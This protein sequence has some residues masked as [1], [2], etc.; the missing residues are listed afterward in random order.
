MREYRRRLPHRDTEGTPVF[1]TWRLHGSLPAERVFYREHL[2]SGKAFVAYDRLLDTA[3]SGPLFMSQPPVASL[4]Q[5]H[6]TTI[7]AD[8]CEL[9]AY[10]IMPN[11][12]HMLCTPN[13][14]LPSLIR[15]I[16]G[17]TARWAN[18]LLG[19]SGRPFWQE[20]YFDR[21]VGSGDEFHRVWT[22]IEWNPVKAHL[23]VTPEDFAWSSAAG[24]KPHAG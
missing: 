3:T 20:E 7:G 5:D 21:D 16:K 9:H 19:L 23:A 15:R 24:L 14:S 18:E 13:I 22:Y 17:P 2:T 10:V 11:H 6:L 8:L 4:I 12:V 1:L